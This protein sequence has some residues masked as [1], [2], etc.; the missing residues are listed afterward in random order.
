[1]NILERTSFLSNKGQSLRRSPIVQVGAVLVALL[2]TAGVGGCGKTAATVIPD[3]VIKD[4]VAKH[5]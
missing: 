4:Y 2:L 5:E 3:G 1:M